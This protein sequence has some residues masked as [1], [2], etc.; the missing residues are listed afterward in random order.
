MEILEKEISGTESLGGKG[1]TVL[2]IDDV[3]STLDIINCTLC[4][5]YNV[6]KM[7]NAKDAL[8][9]M[10]EGNIPDVIICDLKMPE[11]DGFEFMKHV[12]SSGFFRD[13]PL[14]ILSSYES[15]NVKIQCLKCGADDYI[16][17]PFNPEELEARVE[18]MV[19]RT[20]R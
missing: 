6:V 1:K 16:I 17:K 14:L 18:N 3:N 11:M 19:R 7:L 20:S 9:W 15:S 13:I 12:R 10:Q 2:A 5:K 4:K 8:E